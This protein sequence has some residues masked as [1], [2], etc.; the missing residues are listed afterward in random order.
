MPIRDR[1]YEN[2]LQFFGGGL[3]ALVV[4]LSVLQGI[5]RLMMHF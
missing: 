2:A 5:I 3:I 1:K 4:I